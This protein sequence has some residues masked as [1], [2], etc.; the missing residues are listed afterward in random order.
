MTTTT[1]TDILNRMG[2][3]DALALPRD[4]YVLNNLMEIDHVIA[5]HEDGTV[6]DAPAGVYAP[7]RLE[8]GEGP[9]GK[10]DPY[11]MLGDW[12]LITTG[13]S[14]QDR[15]S[16]PIMHNSEFIGGRLAEDILAEPGYYVALACYWPDDEDTTEEDRET[17]GDYVEGWAVA[18]LDIPASV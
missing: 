15:Y 10:V 2:M 8:H 4:P 16:G 18:R 9:D 5:V 17:D 3:G 7:E 13:Y 14:G 11:G 12:T 1:A 6:T